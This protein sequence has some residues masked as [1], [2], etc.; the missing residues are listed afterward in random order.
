MPIYEFRCSKCE[1]VFEELVPSSANGTET[2][3]RCEHC[4]SEDITR[5]L[6]GFAVNSASNTRS[7]PAPPPG[8]CGSSC[9]CFPP[10]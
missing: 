4:E 6:S 2:A 3:V 1:H 7:M 8:P 5:L 10:D 9:A